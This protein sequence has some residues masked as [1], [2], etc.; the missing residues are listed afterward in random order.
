MVSDSLC[1]RLYKT[2]FPRIPR[3]PPDYMKALD[4]ND[5]LNVSQRKN[6]QPRGFRSPHRQCDDF[7]AT[8]FFCLFPGTSSLHTSW[9]GGDHCGFIRVKPRLR[10]GH[11]CKNVCFYMWTSSHFVRFLCQERVTISVVM[12]YLLKL[13][14]SPQ[15]RCS[16]M[17]SSLFCFFHVVLHFIILF[18]YNRNKNGVDL[19]RLG[20]KCAC[21]FKI[22]I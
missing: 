10:S 12:M 22:F 5:R 18:K 1:F 2:V 16:C 21:F 8:F 13:D 17:F 3:P 19:L 9:G 20:N 4:K 6:K 15:V 11:E 14:T 7:C